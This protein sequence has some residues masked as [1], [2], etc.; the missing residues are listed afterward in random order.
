MIK[1]RWKDGSSGKQIASEEEALMYGQS[2]LDEGAI[3]HVADKHGFENSSLF[4]RF[5]CDDGTARNRDATRD[6][7]SKAMQI[8]RRVHGVEGSS[9][10]E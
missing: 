6:I 3:H 9:L 4:Y 5:R 8:Y 7:A 10:G 2:L 1:N